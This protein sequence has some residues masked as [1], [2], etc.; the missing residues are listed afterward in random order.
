MPEEIVN[1]IRRKETIWKKHMEMLEIKNSDV[2]MKNIFD[3]HVRRLDAG[4]KTKNTTE[5]KPLQ[6]KISQYNL[7]YAKKMIHKEK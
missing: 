7:W 5:D 6:R 2:E 3:G 4:E 1:I